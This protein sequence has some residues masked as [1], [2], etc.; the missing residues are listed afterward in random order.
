L[1]A[2]R[3]YVSRLKRLSIALLGSASA[4]YGDI[5]KDEQEVLAQIADVIIETY[6][7]ESGVARAEKMA[8]KGDGRAG[9]AADIAA[10]YVNDAADRVAAASRQVVA[11]L[12]ARGVDASLAAGVQRLAAYAGI[13]AIAARRRIADAVIAAGKYPL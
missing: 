10:V 12:N 2:E 13:D 1:S 8:S 11:A 4:A 5:L 9:L 3:E 6:A 7:T